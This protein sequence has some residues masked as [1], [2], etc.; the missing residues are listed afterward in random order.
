VSLLLLLSLGSAYVDLFGG[1]GTA[2]HDV[3][4]RTTGCSGLKAM[5]LCKAS[6]SSQA[7]MLP[8]MALA[9]PDIIP[10]LSQVGHHRTTD[11]AVCRAY[12][13]PPSSTVGPFPDV[14][15]GS[16]VA[17]DDRINHVATAETSPGIQPS[18]SRIMHVQRDVD[19]EIVT[20]WTRS[21]A[22]QPVTV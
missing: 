12:G 20:A 17:Q 14:R 21:H 4:S 3:A 13:G 5:P 10:R 7:R 18:Q 2:A 15:D 6:S 16:L 22:Q 9:S 19:E 8:I 11:I 1:R